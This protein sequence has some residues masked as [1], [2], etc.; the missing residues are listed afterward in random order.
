MLSRVLG[1]YLCLW[2]HLVVTPPTRLGY[3]AWEVW[4][5]WEAVWYLCPPGPFE[6]LEGMPCSNPGL[7]GFAVVAVFTEMA[8]KNA[9]GH[10]CSAIWV[11]SPQPGHLL[12]PPLNVVS[13]GGL[14]KTALWILRG[15][16]YSAWTAWPSQ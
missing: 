11:P 5:S 15:T 7:S 4:Q 2:V 8:H 14:A 12:L 1:G 3:N 13:M 16:V 6:G 9:S 10:S